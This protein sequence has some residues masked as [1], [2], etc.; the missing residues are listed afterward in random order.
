MHACPYLLHCFVARDLRNHTSMKLA[1]PGIVPA[2]GSMAAA[3]AM[4]HASRTT[5]VKRCVEPRAACSTAQDSLIKHHAG[6]T[7]R[8]SFVRGTSGENLNMTVEKWP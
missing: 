7:A 6:E 5:N 4:S 1:R 8:Y 2:L 3:L